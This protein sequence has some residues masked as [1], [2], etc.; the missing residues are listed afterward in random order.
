MFGDRG[1]DE[2]I[3]LLEQEIPRER[4]EAD[5]RALRRLITLHDRVGAYLTQLRADPA[6]VGVDGSETAA[7]R[8]GEAVAVWGVGG[9]GARGVERQHREE[10]RLKARL[11]R[12]LSGVPGVEL[13]SPADPTGTAEM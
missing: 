12:G 10:S 9:L 5:E 8:P 4:P 13:R 11:H 1:L 3:P 2:H 7:T 6:F